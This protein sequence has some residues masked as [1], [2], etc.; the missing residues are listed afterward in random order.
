M[1]PI[2]I[3]SSSY[4]ILQFYIKNIAQEFNWHY[5]TE[6]C[7]L[8]RSTSYLQKRQ[9]RSLDLS[10]RVGTL[11]PRVTEKTQNH[12]KQ[13]YMIIGQNFALN[14]F[15]ETSFTTYNTTNIKDIKTIVC[16]SH[17]AFSCI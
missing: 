8:S 3:L 12:I 13:S 16:L 17:L 14:I 11:V 1:N 5:I 7:G 6:P 10:K 15:I 4:T 9:R 2:L